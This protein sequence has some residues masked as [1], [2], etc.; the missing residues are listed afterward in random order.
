M[1][2]EKHEC[3]ICPRDRAER[4]Y[5]GQILRGEAQLSV[6]SSRFEHL[7]NLLIHNAMLELEKRGERIDRVT[8]AHELLVHGKLEQAGGLVYIVGLDDEVEAFSL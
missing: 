7:K 1:T 6:H 3:P 4:V 2:E 8:L 5:L